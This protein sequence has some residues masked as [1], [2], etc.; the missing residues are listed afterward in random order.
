MRAILLAALLFVAGG[1]ETLSNPA[2]QRDA[3]KCVYNALKAS[4]NLQGAEAYSIDGARYAVE[5]AF[6][7]K[8][9]QTLIGDVLISG[10]VGWSV[11]GV[12]GETDV[13]GF[14]ELDALPDLRTQCRLVPINDHLYPPPKPRSKWKRIDLHD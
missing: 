7:Y 4:P 3:V 11:V 5:Y 10:A 6:R 1:K 8:N 14:A 12:H 9:G 2:P 13:E